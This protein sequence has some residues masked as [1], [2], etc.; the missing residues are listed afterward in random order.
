M[1]TIDLS[2]S[3]PPLPAGWKGTPDDLL[4]F[5]AEE[6]VFKIEGEFPAAQVGGARPTQDVGIWYGDKSIEKF[7]E[8]K[9]QPISD[10]PVGAIFPFA[11]LSV[12]PENYLLCD[13]RLILRDEYAELFKVIGTAYNR[14]DDVTTSFRLPDYRGRT[15]VGAGVGDYIT[16]GVTGNMREVVAGQYSGFEWV[17]TIKKGP[18]AP[19]TAKFI[20]ATTY[21]NNT[22]N[23]TESFP[24]R[25]GQQFIIRYR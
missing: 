25:I 24:P 17:R 6:G 16:Q 8:G 22:A 5:L 23:M 3:V 7:V 12:A 20:S 21:V 1:S 9:Y 18:G 19:K 13:G 15:P 10:V 14:A 4:Q 2:V 11:G